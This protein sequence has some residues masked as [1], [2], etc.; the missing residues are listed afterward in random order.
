MIMCDSIEMIPDKTS[1]KEMSLKKRAFE[2]V[3]RFFCFTIKKLVKDLFSV[4]FKICTGYDEMLLCI[5]PEKAP[6]FFSA[7]NVTESGKIESIA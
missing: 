4:D 1:R 3:A 7:G 5:P 6:A 2:V